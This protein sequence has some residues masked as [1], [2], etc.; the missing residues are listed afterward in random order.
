MWLVS[1]TQPLQIGSIIAYALVWGLLLSATLFFGL[2]PFRGIVLERDC[3]RI[4]GPW[5][6]R[7][8]TVEFARLRRVYKYEIISIVRF[9]GLLLVFGNS[10]SGTRSLFL[11]FGQRDID[12]LNRLVTLLLQRA[13]HV[14]Y[15]GTLAFRSNREFFSFLK[16]LPATS[17]PE[18]L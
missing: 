16:R 12:S 10:G 6:I 14:K 4:G 7:S 1:P 11:E 13:P 9:Q 5:S 18:A 15:G 3:V 17:N 2:Y 8:R